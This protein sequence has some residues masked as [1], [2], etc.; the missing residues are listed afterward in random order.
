MPYKD[1]KSPEAIASRKKCLKKYSTNN[2]DKVTQSRKNWR[3]KNPNYQRNYMKSRGYEYRKNSDLKSKY[4]IT[5]E[6]YNTMFE[7]QHGCCAICNI[8]GLQLKPARW[9][10]TSLAVDHNHKT[11]KVRGLLCYQCNTMLGAAKDNAVILRLGAD[12]LDK[13]TEEDK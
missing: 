1:P 13:Y 11:G 5:L 8:D 2:K 9:G 12:Y 6:Q 7:A 4:G 3:K 10:K